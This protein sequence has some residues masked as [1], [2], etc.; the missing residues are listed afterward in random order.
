MMLSSSMRYVSLH[1]TATKTDK[2]IGALQVGSKALLEINEGIY[3]D[4]TWRPQAL[5]L[6]WTIIDCPL[7]ITAIYGIIP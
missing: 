3:P 1:I 6:D 4:K 7:L 2:P 5:S